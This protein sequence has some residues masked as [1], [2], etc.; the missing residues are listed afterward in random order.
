MKQKLLIILIVLSNQLFAQNKIE[1]FDIKS[2]YLQETRTVNI[3]LPEQYELSTKEYPL[4][5]TLDNDLLFNTTTA[6]TNQLSKT[7]RMPESIVVSFSAGGKHRNYYSPNLYNNHRDRKYNYGNHQEELLGFLENELLP[8]I[9][10]KYRVA[11]FRIMIGFSPSSVFSLHSLLIKPDLFQAYICFAAGNIIGDGYAKDERLIEELE[12]LYGKQQ[13]TQ[14]YLYVVS[15]SKDAEGQPY[16]NSNVKDFNSKLLK[17]NSNNIHTKAEII[18]GEGHTDV[19]LPGL[20]SALDFIFPKEKW[21]VDYLD[22]IEK[23]G[24]AKENILGFYKNLSKSYGFRVY[25]NTDRLYSMSCIKN[26]GRRLLG[27]KKTEEAIE[28]YEYWTT[29]YPKSHLAYYFL[30][31]SYKENA[32]IIKAGKAYN[33]AY[34]LALAQNSSDADLYKKSFESLEQDKD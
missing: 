7:S 28:L 23:Q 12:K 14:N 10:K 1:H 31:I 4:I 34:E 20:I 3:A 19:V 5:L 32:S 11:K 33:K 6:I 21:I 27:T 15:G 17:Y 18:E 30:G 16:I 13:L 22:L 25:P 2:K 9:E 24:S 8:L 26:V 29:L